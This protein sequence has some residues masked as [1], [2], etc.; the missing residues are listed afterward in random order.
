MTP[1]LRIIDANANRAREALRVMED[2]ARFALDD[3]GLSA[4][5][6]ETRHELRTSLALLPI[7][8]SMLLAWRDTPEDV[9]T[10]ISTPSERA[11]GGLADVAASAGARLTEALRSIEESAKTLPG[12]HGDGPSRFERLR[13]RAYELERLLLSATGTGAARQWRL[14]VLITESLCLGRSR[15]H[16]A[17]SAVAG[18]ADCIQLREKGLSDSELLEAA[19]SL[20]EVTRRAGT[21]LIVNDRPDIA[22]LS[23]ADGVHVGQTDLSVREVRRLAG[24]ALL[25]GV[26]AST[27]EEARR[28]ARDGADYCGLGP[29]FA[30]T[31]KNKPVISGPGLVRDWLA[32]TDSTRLPHLAIG[33]V[34]PANI[35][36]LAGA[37]VRGV[38]VSSAV[39]SAPDPASVCREI[40]AALDT[41][42]SQ[43]P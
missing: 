32:T 5:L 36:G 21:A 2:V 3:A 15:E 34:T 1:A 37:G 29:M 27:V 7:D 30:T 16:V 43:T 9:G 19:R 6:K 17:E 11:R 33:G 20:R 8:R 22:L 24:R 13:Y 39:C 4:A 25:V 18:G 10:A 42:Q 40:C 26:S 28:A 23:R 38:A 14:C 41:A 31:T 12:V 35:A